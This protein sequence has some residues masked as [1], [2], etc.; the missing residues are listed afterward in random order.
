MGS[1]NRD[2]EVQWFVE[3]G[4]CS[5]TLRSSNL[6]SGDPE[7]PQLVGAEAVSLGARAKSSERPSLI[8]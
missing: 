1:V 2:A 7:V 8:V 4:W 5:S 6:G 3:G